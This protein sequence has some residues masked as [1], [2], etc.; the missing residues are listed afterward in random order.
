MPYKDKTSDVARKSASKASSR[1][2]KEN[3]DR[4]N[5]KRNELHKKKKDAL[6]AHLGGQCVGCGTTHNLQFDHIDRT[7]KKYRSI[8]SHLNRKMEDLIEEANKCQLLCRTCHIA[9]SRAHYDHEELLKGCTLSSIK[10]IDNQI[11]ITYNKG[12]S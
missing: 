8:I 11:I 10:T 4:V 3:K 12:E 9:K 7:Q 6:I 2:N 5:A 1:W